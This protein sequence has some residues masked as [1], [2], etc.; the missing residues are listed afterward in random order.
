VRARDAESG[1]TVAH[2]F[3]NW[4][5]CNVSILIDCVCDGEPPSGRTWADIKRAALSDVRMMARL[6]KLARAI[7]DKHERGELSA[8]EARVLNGTTEEP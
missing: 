5:L 3:E 4:D 1:N 8:T 6:C 7:V 2:A